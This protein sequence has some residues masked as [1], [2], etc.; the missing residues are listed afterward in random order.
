MT[1]GGHEPSDAVAGR[2]EDTGPYQRRECAREHEP[3]PCHLK[4]AGDNRDEG[5]RH[6]DEFAGDDASH[7]VIEDA[8]ACEIH[9]VGVGAQRPNPEDVFLEV[10]AQG[11]GHKITEECSGG[12]CEP[13]RP[14][15]SANC[16][17]CAADS[18]KQYCR[19]NEQRQK[20]RAFSKSE[21]KH[22]RLGPCDVLSHQLN[23]RVGPR[24]GRGIFHGM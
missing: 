20:H 22:K 17:V 11:V 23:N 8:A 3:W 1:L 5:A 21:S 10:A 2:E 6:T 16:A 9:P 13:H 24:W 15:Y 4:G 12:A 7:S 18:E 19:G 14:E